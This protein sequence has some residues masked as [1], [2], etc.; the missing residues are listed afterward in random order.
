MTPK[1][2]ELEILVAKIQAQLAPDA[3]VSHDVRLLGRYSQRTRQ[4]DVLVKQRIGQHEMLIVLEAK[5]Y[6]RPVDVKSVEEFQGLLDDVGAHKGALVAPR[7]F[8]AAAKRRAAALKIDLYSPVDTDPHKWTT[9]IALPMVCSFKSC[10]FAIG[11]R[12]VG[13]GPLRVPMDFHFTSMIYDAEGNELGTCA[14][15]AELLWTK[16][17]VPQE[18]GEHRNFPLFSADPTFLDNG[19]GTRIS[20]SLTA[21]FL[22]KQQC[23]FGELPVS[24]ISGFYDAADETVI[25]NSMTTS[26]LD[27]EEV[28][29]KWQR[30]DSVEA[31]PRRPVLIVYGEGRFSD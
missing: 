21:S 25:A 5:D 11:M 3:E 20:V 19:Y 7:G 31:A 28:I 13:I 18:P 4:I 24:E 15:A 14:E 10:Q 23:Y 6:N 8:S 27:L 12:G 26:W 17:V 29:A 2:R 30:I 22:V 16:E 1:S 9:S